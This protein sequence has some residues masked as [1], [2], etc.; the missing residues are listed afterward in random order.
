MEDEAGWLL[1][2]VIANFVVLSDNQTFLL[3]IHCCLLASHDELLLVSVQLLRLAV[4]GDV[5]VRA[6]VPIGVRGVATTLVLFQYLLY[7]VHHIFNYS[8][9]K[10][11]HPILGLL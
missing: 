3:C 9:F 7:C 8:N 2:S 6:G 10:F 1:T 11:K 4:R 5:G